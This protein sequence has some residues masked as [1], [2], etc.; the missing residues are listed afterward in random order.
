M[1]VYDYK[2]ATHGVFNELATM[3]DFD[4][5]CPCQQCG[6]LSGR[7][8]MLAPEFLDMAKERRAAFATNEKAQNEPIFST[9]KS[10]QLSKHEG[11][12]GCS[13]HK[14]RASNLMYTAEGNKFFPSM[15]PWM[16]SH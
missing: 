10:R 11:G 1:P 15:R 2:C 6:A 7:V 9:D 5:P 8:I 14:K 4:K 13:N 16:I 12:C 3:A